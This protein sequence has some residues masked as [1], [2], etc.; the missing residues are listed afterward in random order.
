MRINQILQSVA[1]RQWEISPEPWRFYQ[2]WNNAVFLHW[3]VVPDLIRPHIPATVELDTFQGEAWI[4]LV[5]FTMEKLRVSYLPSV[6]GVSNFHEINL[7]TYV[8]KDNKP[9]VYFLSIEAQKLLAVFIAKSISG[10]P[11]K[12]ASIKRNYDGRSNTY[13]SNNPAKGFALES[14]YETDTQEYER[15]DLDK[16]LVERYCLYLDPD[17][18]LF[19]YDIHHL[20]WEIKRIELKHLK[21]QYKIGDLVLNEKQPDLSHFSPGVKVLAWPRKI[22]RG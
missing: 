20:Q 17:N 3:R 6:P 8:T 9:G 2:E 19:R 12:K 16:W 1:H 10:L 14:S 21:L 4:S 11:Y 18:K 13:L 5:A 7:R 15:T 22:V